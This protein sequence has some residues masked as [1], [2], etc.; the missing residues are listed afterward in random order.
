MS[1]LS[2]DRSDTDTI[3][4]K[5]TPHS[6]PDLAQD[7]AVSGSHVEYP[8]T[9]DTDST[10][11]A[12]TKDL[13]DNRG[14]CVFISPSVPNVQTNMPKL[15]TPADFMSKQTNVNLPRT[16][17]TSHSSFIPSVRP[18]MNTNTVPVLRDTQGGLDL[19]TEKS[20]GSK[21]L[22]EIHY[23]YNIHSESQSVASTP[24]VLCQSAEHSHPL[25]QTYTVNP[26]NV[27]GA[28]LTSSREVTPRSVTAKGEISEATSTQDVQKEIVRIR[29][30][31]KN[32]EQKKKKLRY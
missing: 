28:T 31:L 10:R 1:N 23:E 27:R 22:T 8:S 4:F 15:L 24:R 14:K 11:A 20:V 19:K 26:G 29:N 12:N 6:G 32:F 30:R 18:D 7:V 16:E 13:I 9:K 3:P 2:G 5:S 21:Q 17:V 25:S